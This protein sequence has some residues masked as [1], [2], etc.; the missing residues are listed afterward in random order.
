MSIISYSEFIRV[1]RGQGQKCFKEIWSSLGHY[2]SRRHLTHMLCTFQTGHS[3]F[4][5]GHPGPES[6]HNQGTLS[7]GTSVCWT[8]QHS[9]GEP[10]QMWVSM[11]Y[12]RNWTVLGKRIW[13][14]ISYWHRF[15]IKN[16]IYKEEMVQN[17]CYVLFESMIFI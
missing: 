14:K 17:Q 16:F 5:V 9:A 15:M 6:E 12:S 8:L 2:A 13:V 4:Q 7:T 10:W 3:L 11:L 1:G